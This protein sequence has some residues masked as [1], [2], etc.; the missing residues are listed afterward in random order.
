MKE[1]LPCPFCESA[2][3]IE[4][5]GTARQSMIVACTNCGCRLESGDIVGMTL[6]ENYKWNTRAN[7]AA[8]SNGAE[9]V[10]WYIPEKELATTDS[11]WAEENAD[12]C[13][14]LFLHAD[15]A[16]VEALRKQNNDMADRNDRLWQERDSPPHQQSQHRATGAINAAQILRGQKDD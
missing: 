10:A 12:M 4:R 15:S 11:T 13:E 5:Q 1:L 3:E 2:P 6:P 14:P 16:E 9:P 7:I 8:L